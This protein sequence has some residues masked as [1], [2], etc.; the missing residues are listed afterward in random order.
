MRVARQWGLLDGIAVGVFVAILFE[1]LLLEPWADGGTEPVEA[2]GIA[3]SAPLPERSYKLEEIVGVS[4]T[5]PDEAIRNAVTRAAQTLQGL[6]WFQVI[7]TR[8]TIGQRGVTQFQVTVW[9]GFR[10]MS[11]EELRGGA[12]NA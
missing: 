1:L 6:D 12:G 7:E 4:E 8:C 9:I 10:I 2:P 11:P 3:P 5:S